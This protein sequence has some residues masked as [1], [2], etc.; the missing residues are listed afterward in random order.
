MHILSKSS[1]KPLCF[2]LMEL[3]LNVLKLCLYLLELCL[4]PSN[5]NGFLSAA[6]LLHAILDEKR[7]NTYIASLSSN[8]YSYILPW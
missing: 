3:Y 4:L 7:N 8:K 1:T 2:N 5:R 6:V